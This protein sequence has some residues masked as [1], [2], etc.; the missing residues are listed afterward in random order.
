MACFLADGSFLFTSDFSGSGPSG[1]TISTG[2]PSVA[3][4]SLE[5]AMVLPLRLGSW[6][7]TESGVDQMMLICLRSILLSSMSIISSAP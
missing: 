4:L 5:V 6:L 2:D 1:V 7:I 3:K